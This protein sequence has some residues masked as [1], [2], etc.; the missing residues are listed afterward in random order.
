[1]P[2]TI[3]E[4]SVLLANIAFIEK[5]TIRNSVSKLSGKADF[6]HWVRSVFQ[7]LASKQLAKGSILEPRKIKIYDNYNII[8]VFIKSSL[9]IYP[10]SNLTR[11]SI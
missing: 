7:P 8:N 10:K 2:I 11:L 3:Q 5:P 6:I 4:P 9:Q 1:M